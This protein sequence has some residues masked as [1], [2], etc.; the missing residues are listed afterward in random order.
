[1][2]FPVTEKIGDPALPS[3][4]RPV[5]EMGPQERAACS[6]FYS[7]SGPEGRWG[8]QGRKDLK[9]DIKPWWSVLAPLPPPPRPLQ[10]QLS[11]NHLGPLGS[12]T[13]ALGGP[14][15]DKV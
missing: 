12:G 4:G 13:G 1:M 14:W 3:S 8:F 7:F 9:L 5:P 11:L 15:R 10:A 6:F 2:P